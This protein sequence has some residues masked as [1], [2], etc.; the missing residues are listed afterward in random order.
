MA[1]ILLT[2][3]I[4]AMAIVGLYAYRRMR[5]V[6]QQRISDNEY[7]TAQT[8]KDFAR[9]LKTHTEDMTYRGTNVLDFSRVFVPH[10]AGYRISLELSNQGFK[11]HAVPHK[12]NKT[13]RL[14][15]YIDSTLQVRAC[16]HRGEKATEED[17]A[18]S[19]AADLDWK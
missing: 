1:I 18:Y 17:P 13:G 10:G 7:N 3:A 14:S 16:D 4:T 15:F 11:V 8:L 12:Y 6:Q 2:I 9:F 19:Y 5:E